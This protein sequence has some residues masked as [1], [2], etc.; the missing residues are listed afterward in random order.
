MQKVSLGT[1]ASNIMND[2]W[3]VQR[4]KLEFI[5][6]IPKLLALC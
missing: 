4:F 1:L 2:E 3:K 5:L 6:M